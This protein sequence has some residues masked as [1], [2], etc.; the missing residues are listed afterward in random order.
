MK[1]ETISMI[2]VVFVLAAILLTSCASGA[3][4]QGSASGQTGSVNQSN[5]PGQAGGS[6]LLT[7]NEWSLVQVRRAGMTTAIDRTAP[8][9]FATADLSGWFSLRFQDDGQLNG[10]GAPNRYF[11]PYTAGNNRALSIGTVASTMMASFVELEELKEREYFDYLSRVTR[12]ELRGG[13]LELYS[14]E[15]SGAEVVLIYSPIPN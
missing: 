2:S 14:A 11:G 7:G 1:N 15:V 13:R 4:A 9:A 6:G 10:M 3:T 12:W 8:A 5:A